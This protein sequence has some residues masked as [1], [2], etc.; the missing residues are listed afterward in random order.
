M[1]RFAGGRF[2]DLLQHF[3]IG[4]MLWYAEIIA[5]KHKKM[6]G[7]SVFLRKTPPILIRKGGTMHTNI[8]IL[9]IVDP[10]KPHFGP[11]MVTDE[12]LIGQEV[13][14]IERWGICRERAEFLRPFV[15]R[16][17]S[18]AQFDDLLMEPM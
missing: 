5:S 18:K 4:A 17:M 8:T 10:T 12:R 3:F 15:G 16:T 9:E 13:S 1:H 11:T 14:K 2:L 6:K 7:F